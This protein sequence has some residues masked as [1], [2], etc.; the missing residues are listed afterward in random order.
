MAP[1]TRSARSAAS[2]SANLRSQVAQ[3][4]P[5]EP[6]II[7]IEED[8]DDDESM[9]GEESYG[10]EEELEEE[11]G[12]EDEEMDEEEDGFDDDDD[13]AS[14]PRSGFPVLEPS[15][16]SVMGI[17][18]KAQ[19][20]P[21]LFT[22]AGAQ[23]AFDPLRR[24]A[25]R[26]TKQIEAFA[27]ELDQFKQKNSN[28]EFHN[29]QAAYNL[30]DKYHKLTK[31]AIQENEKQQALKRTKGFRSSEA[32]D[33]K[34]ED[35]LRRLYLELD[36]WRLLLNLISVD[37]PA[38]RASF[39]EGRQTAFQNLH[40]YSSD[41][42]VWEQFLGA[43]QYATECVV[44]MKWLEETAKAEDNEL[45]AVISEMESQ[46]GRGEG[47]WTH[48]WLYTK[49]AIKGHK[50]L[51]AWPQPLEPSDPG[52]AQSMTTDDHKPLIT[53]LDPDA[54]LRQKQHLQ[55]Q[56]EFYEHATWMN[57]WKMLRQGEDWTQI[58][59]WAENRLEGWRAVSLC[60]S[61]LESNSANT[62][63]PVDDG[64]TRLMN[65]R[66][67][68]S[69]RAAC[70]ALAQNP[71]A[72]D[73]ERA[74]YGLLCGDSDSVVKVCSSWD[75]Y[76][77][78]YFNRVVLS[79]YK[80]FCKQFQR[81]LNHSPNT[82]VAFTPEPAGHTDLQKFFQY[83]RGNERVGGEA[84]NPFR[85]LQAAILSKGYDSYFTQLA[86]AVSEYA[87]KAD[88]TASI[89]PDIARSKVDHTYLLAASDE[90]AIKMS[91]HVYLVVQSIGYS[92][93]DTQFLETAS[94][95]LA[96]YIAL[97]E[98]RGL[99]QLIP[100]YV[101][102]MP[103]GMSHDA[104]AKILIDILHPKQRKEQ[105][106]LAQK[107]GVDIDSVLDVQWAYL[108][109]K[110]SSIEYS[111]GLTGYHR[112]VRRPDGS[113]EIL[114]PKKDIIG[115]SIAD[116][117]ENMIR[118]L[119]WLR[120]VGGQWG[121]ICKLGGWLYRKFFIAGKLAA[122]R[123]LSQRMPLP[124]ISQETFGYDIF[125][126]PDLNVDQLVAEK[127]APPSPAKSRK[128]SAH[129]RSLSGSN[130][131]SVNNSSSASQQSTLMY[132]FENLALGF[133]SRENFAI[134]Y[135]QISKTKRRRD[136][137][138]VKNLF[139]ELSEYLGT[140]ESSVG[141]TVEVVDWPGTAETA[142]EEEDYAYIRRTLLPELVL[143]YHTAL[144]YAAE[145]LEKPELLTQCMVVATLVA[146]IPHLTRSFVEAQRMAELMDSL[147]L[148]GRA[149]VFTNSKQDVVKESGQTLGLWRVNVPEH[150]D[151]A[152]P[153]KK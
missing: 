81:K 145:T 77:Y 136:S 85:N 70:F 33:A 128:N 48:G 114:P 152:M 98:A 29:I 113:R 37:E 7:S 53:Q 6:E 69:W 106:R 17:T 55:A 110:V 5:K 104:Y 124:E 19:G 65:S 27:K 151:A 92:R 24:T 45:T 30:V 60:G 127:S 28:D 131:I 82:P 44:A 125:E 89:I 143:D 139:D 99:F 150:G 1:L 97:L 71:K 107:Y 118:S 20:S 88:G 52:V 16:K 46:A 66:A 91:A 31:N 109:S 119:E 64:M 126:Y 12:E 138:T 47:L 96:G 72:G 36:T 135:E 18:S 49:E 95:V 149:M 129:R 111:R 108:S 116:E 133:D 144:Y 117:D 25:D 94:V 140:L 78:V 86:Q 84:S 22:A 67:Q 147:A 75:D 10:N 79:R 26:V 43:D 57:C 58:R 87:I 101:S 153:Q 62:R 38:S 68:D 39:K 121:K 50:R 120:Y 90:E 41:R 105:V 137:G 74:V 148:A 130:G 34:S 4:H 3:P 132:N 83:L 23:E 40:R 134:L 54:L 142:E 61:S 112:L 123:E 141:Q 8:E 51:R 103:T 56:D 42:E 146:K 73:F 32:E 14:D 102:L 63:T 93:V 122:A 76:L 80:G 13:E 100:L 15:L 11:T 59:E 21:Q 115:V 2:G 35:E 9:D